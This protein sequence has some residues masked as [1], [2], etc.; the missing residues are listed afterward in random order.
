LK[1]IIIDD[2]KSMHLIMKRMLS[3]E[4][5]IEIVGSFLETASAF[6]YLMNHEVDLIFADISMPRENGLD[7]AKRLRASGR[8][9]RLVFVTSHKEF[10]SSAFEVYA[11]DF[12]VKPIERVRLHKTLQR[13]LSEKNHNKS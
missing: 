4:D 3:I 2:E 6:T 1:V 13:V 11:Y 12:I 7:F 8:Q 5:E 9:M 10:A